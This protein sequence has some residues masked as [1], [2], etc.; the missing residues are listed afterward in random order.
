M[1][2]L[3]I[4]PAGQLWGSERAL[5]DMIES[6][7][8][9]EFAV[10]CPPDG[11]LLQELLKRR[12]RALPYFIAELH[13]K[14]RW[15]R[16]VAAF[17]VL[18]AILAFQPDVLHVNQAGAY[19]VALSAARL[20]HIPL[21]CHVRLFEDVS[22][23]AARCPNPERLKSMIAISGAV[24]KEIASSPALAAIPVH[25]IYDAYQPVALPKATGR[26]KQNLIVCAGRIAAI[27]GQEVLLSALAHSVM[28]PLGTEC[29]IAGNG[30][31][32]YVSQLKK[33]APE[34]ENVAIKWLGFIEDVFAVLRSA[35]VLACPSHREPLG[36][37][38][39]EAWN[40]G[41]VPVVFAGAGGSAEIVAAA[42]GGILY[43]EQ[44]P[45]C[46]AHA[47]AK[48]MALDSSERDRL[49]ANGRAWMTKNCAPEPYGRA[50][51]AV[52]EQA[53]A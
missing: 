50:V 34:S 52:L 1:R 2:V 45:E 39:F 30:E 53:C 20:L 43:D 5:L 31:S 9:V 7:A 48:A 13:R 33:R 12:I 35:G 36:R 3:V 37:V 25:K 18:R 19:R 44:R 47:L 29:L 10:C 51:A 6:V 17:G 42:G 27:K 28:F 22:Y 4:E 21:V 8:G 41:A 16:L 32:S 14:P 49:I 23:L 40:A 15:R 24:A 46:L 11:P 26:R 38:V